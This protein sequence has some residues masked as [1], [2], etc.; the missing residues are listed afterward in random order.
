[1][2]LQKLAERAVLSPHR[3]REL[4]R[5][6][7]EQRIRDWQPQIVTDRANESHLDEPYHILA[8]AALEFGEAFLAL[9]IAREGTSVLQNLSFSGDPLVHRVLAWLGRVKA[10]A[11]A[12]TGSPETAHKLLTQLHHQLE[13][14]LDIAA[15]LA[16]TYKDLGLAA[17]QSGQRDKALSE[18]NKLYLEAFEKSREYYPGINAAATA[19]WIGKGETAQELAGAVESLC[20]SSLEGDPQNYWVLATLAES[21]LIREEREEALSWFGR[22]RG[23]ID[24]TRKWANLS[25]TRRDARLICEHR[26]IDFEEVDKVLNFPCVIVFAGHMIDRSGR[27]QPRFP[28]ERESDVAERIR[29]Q[30]DDLNVGFGV[31]TAACGSDLLFI[32]GMVESG[33]DV[34]VVL[35][36]KEEDFI[37]SSVNFGP[38]RDWTDR[39]HAALRKAASVTFLSQQ[40]EPRDS[41]LGY[42]YLN[43]CI[44]GLALMRA[45]ELG[46]KLV[47]LAVY[48]GKGGDGPGG[49]SSFVGFWK[50]HGYKPAIIPLQS[51]GA[52]VQAGR[53]ASEDDARS[54]DSPEITVSSGQLATKTM[55]FCDVQ[56]YTSVPERDLP[57]FVNRFLGRISKL[58]D[59]GPEQPIFENTWGDAIYLVFD[60][61]VKAGRFAL[62]LRALVRDTDWKKQQLPPNLTLRV[63]LHTG[64]VLL[65]VDPVIRRMTF[66]GSHVS[67]TARIEPKTAPGEIWTSE[68]FAAHA[69]I[70]RLQ[71][72]LGFS[73]DYLGHI[74]LAKEY[75]TYPLFRLTEEASTEQ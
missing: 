25:T 34:K 49:T 3:I 14:D 60:D 4:W 35:P 12:R 17:P 15:A 27:P 56:H 46:A 71:G 19:L 72:R 2:K 1:M 38:N 69:A 52:P 44:Q 33:R 74:E 55:L 65:C 23:V 40:T 42:E 73:L 32:E 70:A 62:R 22:A 64:P 41:Q 20:R 53:T 39:F 48:D 43:R 68:A 10:I 66:T 5:M 13:D 29:R 28:P 8:N 59:E 16:R 50:K 36:W 54:A 63:S 9:E 26:S 57:L 30:I 21:L 75:G 37:R 67:H 58:I 31:C 47:P 45:N 61:V 11:F 18:A 6:G 24:E 51:V 7:S